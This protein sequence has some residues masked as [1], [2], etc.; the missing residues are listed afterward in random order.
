[1]LYCSCMICILP[2]RLF[3]SFE[4]GPELAIHCKS[5][6]CESTFLLINLAM[7][8]SFMLRINVKNN[9]PQK[10]TYV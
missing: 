6:C 5:M 1:M 4:P 8:K 10:M 2:L 9:C 3:A 7:L